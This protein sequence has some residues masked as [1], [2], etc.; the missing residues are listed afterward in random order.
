VEH[1]ADELDVWG[2]VGVL[3]C[4]VQ[5]ELEEAAFPGGAVGSFD[6][7]G[8][9]EEVILLGRGHDIFPLLLLDALQVF[10]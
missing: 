7:G 5:F 8:P 1:F 10:Q 4:E 2:F 6:G 9:F 3:L